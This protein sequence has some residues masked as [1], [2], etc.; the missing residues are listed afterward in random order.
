[1]ITIDSNTVLLIVPYSFSISV[2]LF[3]KLTKLNGVNF[4][5]KS[6][7]RFTESET[8]DSPG[9]PGRMATLI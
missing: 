9:F 1:M 5:L 8:G 6:G 2:I 3:N 4:F 7:H